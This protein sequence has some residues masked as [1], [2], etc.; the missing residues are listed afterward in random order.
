[1]AQYTIYGLFAQANE[2]A[3]SD[4]PRRPRGELGHLQVRGSLGVNQTWNADHIEGNTATT[5]VAQVMATLR[6]G[7]RGALR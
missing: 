5:F 7:K 2:R 1:M 4:T 3:Q 6:I